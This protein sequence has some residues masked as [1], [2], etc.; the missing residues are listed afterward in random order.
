[1]RLGSSLKWRVFDH[2]ST[3]NIN[4][5]HKRQKTYLG[6][7]GKSQPVLQNENTLKTSCLIE[8]ALRFNYVLW[9]RK[10]KWTNEAKQNNRN[11]NWN[12]AGSLWCFWT[13][14]NNKYQTFLNQEL[15]CKHGHRLCIS[16]IM[17]INTINR[18]TITSYSI[19]VILYSSGKR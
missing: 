2:E 9:M 17:I 3:W 11:I 10:K 19:L 6:V 1:M 8:E 4:T 5:C 16:D 12:S 13:S 7:T 18:L 14:M 15:Q